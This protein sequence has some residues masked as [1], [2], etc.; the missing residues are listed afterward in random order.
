M[1]RQLFIYYRIPKADIA[2]GL[3]C[4][5]RLASQLKQQGL[6]HSQLFQREEVDKPYFTLMEVIHPAPEFS[7]CTALFTEKLEQM[8]ATCFTD[9][10]SL[11]SRHLELFT[12]LPDEVNG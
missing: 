8:A 3:R 11:P 5:R 7:D 9:L 10:P 12:E 4:A 1:K 2:L 6:G